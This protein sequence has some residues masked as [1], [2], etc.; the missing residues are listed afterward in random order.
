MGKINVTSESP[1][2]DTSVVTLIKTNTTLEHSRK[3]ENVSPKNVKAT[4]VAHKPPHTQRWD[5][6][7]RWDY[8]RYK[9]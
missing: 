7:L 2:G 1:V 9:P 6:L 4:C 3:A 8:L 5:Q